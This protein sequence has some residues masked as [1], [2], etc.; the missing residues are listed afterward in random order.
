MKKTRILILSSILLL[1]SF[2]A[3]CNGGDNPSPVVKEATIILRSKDKQNLKVGEGMTIVYS[4][5]NSDSEV[6]FKSDNEDIV[7]CNE[8]GEVKAINSGKATVTLSLKEDPSVKKTIEFEITRNFFKTENGY[9][10]GSVDLSQQDNGTSLIKDGQAQVLADFPGTSWYFKTHLNR[11]GF[12]EAIGGW[13][14]GSFLVN[15]TN[16]IGDIMYWYCLRRANDDNHAKLY[17]GG[18]R[19]DTS[20]AL[21]KE[22]LVSD[23][24]IDLTNGVDFTIY[25]KGIT[26]YLI[27][28]YKSEG[29]TK[30]IKHTYDV[31]LFLGQDTFPGVFGQ[32]QKIEISKFE[33]SNDAP[34]VEKKLE[35]FQLAE[36]IK[37]NAIDNRLIKGRT[38]KLTST[39]LPDY[40]IN[41]NV[42][43]TLS[44][45]VSGVKLT[46]DG[47]LTINN[48]TKT[49]ELKVKAVALSNKEVF[50]E[51]TYKLIDEIPSKDPL[52]NTNLFIGEPLIKENKIETN[53]D[54]TYIPFNEKNTTW[55]VETDITL[56]EVSNNKEFGI[57][58]TSEG[59][60]EYVK[61]SY[62]G[63]I[64][65][66]TN[67]LV[68]ELNGDELTIKDGANGGLTG[69]NNKLG[70][71]RKDNVYY[72]FI[73]NKMIKKFESN[74]NDATYPV[75][76]SS[77]SATFTNYS[78]TSDVSKI[79]EVLNNNDFFIGSY[80]KKE[81]NTYVL[82]NMDLGSESDINWP[83]V[84]DYLNGIKYKESLKQ[85]FEINFTLSDINPLVLGNGDIDAKVLVYLKSERVTS[86]IQFVIKNY[87]GVRKVKATIN[88]NDATWTE[89]DL[90][91]Q[92]DLLNEDT[93]V[94][95][96]RTDK[97]VELYLN[98]VRVFEGEKFMKNSNYWGKK[99]VATP[100]I[101]TFKCG[102]TIKDPK[103]ILK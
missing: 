12:S 91:A 13:G 100:G 7:T 50:D 66:N 38:Y 81:N 44:E 71:L 48:D 94:R 58:S 52:F 28:E 101:G 35:S 98:D 26:H 56:N 78:Y 9:V 72:L 55:F 19:Y 84:N 45:E 8:F 22:T 1:S 69:L 62:K 73:N 32:N 61:Y 49:E 20:V 53:E 14:V 54:E 40:T 17:Y 99:T 10:N 64:S 77:A 67:L 23:E 30:T 65:K 89:H 39:I 87:N 86:S 2:A 15:D 37:I 36:A 47:T 18:W 93:K 88:L 25:R 43:Y 76:Y 75:L 80:V 74:L 27:L 57:L 95:I 34:T 102:A 96:V 11:V 82:Q 85:N 59:Y 63:R 29:V 4:V 103:I 60:S 68:E 83:P 41:K 90:P 24:I 5:V 92:F 70:L 31:P 42:E 21:S 97:E 46:K 16:R 6:V 51:K 3:S 33:G 79:N